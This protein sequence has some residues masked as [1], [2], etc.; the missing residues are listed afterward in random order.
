MYGQ[1]L[2]NA[3]LVKAG[4]TENVL[5]REEL[6]S[7]AVGKGVAIPHASD[8]YIITP[9]ICVIKLLKPIDW[10]ESKVDVVFLLALKFQDGKSTKS[11]FKEFYLMLDNE[12]VINKIRKAKTGKEIV[13]TILGRNEL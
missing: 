10:G 9:N 12:A 7:T 6:T 2:E 1:V 5:N 8:E 13:K 4:F 11:F 3:G